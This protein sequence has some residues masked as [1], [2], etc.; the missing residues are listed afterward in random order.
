MIGR[1]VLGKA[2][3]PWHLPICML[4]RR[5]HE[6][7][8]PGPEKGQSKRDG[9]AWNSKERS[10]RTKNTKQSLKSETVR[11]W[12]R[13]NAVGVCMAHGVAQQMVRVVVKPLCK[14]RPQ[15][16]RKGPGKCPACELC[17]GSSFLGLGSYATPRQARSRGDGWFAALITRRLSEIQ[18]RYRSR[19]VC[20]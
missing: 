10:A 19:P 8:S 11:A 18:D 5:G 3:L 15:V 14:G 1:A 9:N 17:V 2:P 7:P 4:G 6:I 12:V 20:C 13:A 16:S